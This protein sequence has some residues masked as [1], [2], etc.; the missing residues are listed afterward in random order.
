VEGLRAGRRVLRLI[1]KW[2]RAGVIQDGDWSETV[3]GTP[4]GASI[5]T[6]IANVYLHYVFDLWVHQW[7]GRHARG[8]T[9]V[10][11]FADDAVVGLSIVMTL[12][13]SSFVFA[14]GSRSSTWS[15]RRRRRG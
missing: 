14:T 13:G 11:R 9:I 15:W 7:R 12:S 5:S 2:L 10:V 1:Q 8:E 6:L 4:Q 3:E